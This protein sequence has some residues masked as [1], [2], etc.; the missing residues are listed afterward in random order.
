MRLPRILLVVLGVALAGVVMGALSG[1]VVVTVAIVAMKLAVNLELSPFEPVI[2]GIAAL[3]GGA[4]G[5]VLGP[6]ASFGFLRHVPL[7]R[8]F[9][10]GALGTIVASVAAAF[11]TNSLLPV[12]VAGVVGFLLAE[13]R[14]AV[15]S[16]RGAGARERAEAR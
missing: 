3:I 10:E 4:M 9:A 14:L 7:W 6:A 12:L 16:R 5:A 11:L 1:M 13:A 2:H 15:A 8:I